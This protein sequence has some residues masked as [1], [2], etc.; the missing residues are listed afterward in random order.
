MR[1]KINKDDESF[2]VQRLRK[3]IEDYKTQCNKLQL[4][5]ESCRVELA[6]KNNEIQLLHN[7][8]DS[9][10]A[11][12]EKNLELV[13]ATRD[14]YDAAKKRFALVQK[15]YQKEMDAWIKAVR[16]TAV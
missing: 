11:E 14:A 13:K 6:K 7:R 9:V 16:R 3:I 15:E 10:I 8:M 12:Y 5:L 1:H 4:E 2:K